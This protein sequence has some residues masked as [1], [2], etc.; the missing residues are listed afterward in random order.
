[1]LWSPNRSLVMRGSWG[2]EV[3]LVWCFMF[4]CLILS[5]IWPEY[6][7]V[8]PSYWF[9]YIAS[10]FVPPPR[11]SEFTF[12]CSIFEVIYLC[13]IFYFWVHCHIVSNSSQEKFICMHMV[14]PFG[15]ATQINSLQNHMNS[16]ME[17]FS[18]PSCRL[19][20]GWDKIYS[21]YHR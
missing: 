1:M 7:Y 13:L 2:L 10:R 21:S 11:Q 16:M 9:Y 14:W 19:I 17:F 8:A 4:S 15:W 6:L 3:L 20:H 12:I 5:V 18:F